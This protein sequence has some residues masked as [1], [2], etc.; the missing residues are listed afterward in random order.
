M[1]RC[2]TLQLSGPA[3]QQ[4]TLQANGEGELLIEWYHMQGFVLIRD[5]G[6]P[7]HSTDGN[8][9]PVHCIV[10]QLPVSWAILPE[11][12]MTAPPPPP[13]LRAVDSVRHSGA[14]IPSE[15]CVCVE[16]EKYRA[17]EA[18]ARHPEGINGADHTRQP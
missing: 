11:W 17:K 12:E 14:V 4:V 10:A 18:I 8:G 16:C 7:P 3:G 9:K 6:L 1:L 5:T 2:A 13:Q 15:G